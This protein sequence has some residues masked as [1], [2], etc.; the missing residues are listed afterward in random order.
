MSK[1]KKQESDVT[2]EV[3]NEIFLE[4]TP[5]YHHIKELAEKDLGKE[6]MDRIEKFLEHKD[7]PDVEEIKKV[8]FE[9]ASKVSD[10]N[11][12][13]I[14]DAF[15]R[16]RSGESLG[17]V[18]RKS[19]NDILILFN[20]WVTLG[21]SKQELI[22]PKDIFN[23]P[24]TER[25]QEKLNDLEEQIMTLRQPNHEELYK[26]HSAVSPLAPAA[27]Y[28][29]SDQRIYDMGGPSEFVCCPDHNTEGYQSK[30]IY[31]SHGGKLNFS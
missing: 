14:V 30:T 9:D 12:N 7:Q 10:T 20:Q 31:K 26:T 19:I 22:M 28:A 24:V 1:E 18:D 15:V 11:I 6:L 16:I 5:E 13:D 27:V 8:V 21:N 29:G 2:L 4:D 17:N 25:K 23:E 3:I